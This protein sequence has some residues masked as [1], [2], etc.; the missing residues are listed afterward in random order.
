MLHKQVTRPVFINRLRNGMHVDVIVSTAPWSLSYVSYIRFT[1]G[2]LATGAV[3]RAGR[4]SHAISSPRWILDS[5]VEVLD[6][7]KWVHNYT[8]ALY[9]LP[10]TSLPQY[11]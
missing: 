9:I 2:K 6:L 5:L 3:S 11:T 8:P 7:P 1:A 10:M 4:K